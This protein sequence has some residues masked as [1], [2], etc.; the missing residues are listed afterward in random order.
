GPALKPLDSSTVPSMRALLEQA[1]RLGEVHAGRIDE[2]AD[3]LVNLGLPVPAIAASTKMG[4]EARSGL[5]LGLTARKARSVTGDL[6]SSESV[7]ARFERL[8]ARSKRVNSIEAQE[9]EETL[10]ALASSP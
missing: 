5:L 4:V 8:L 6:G 7:L 3:I 2:V 1:R 10:G 9:I